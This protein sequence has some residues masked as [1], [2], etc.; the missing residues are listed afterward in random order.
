MGLGFAGGMALALGWVC[1]IFEPVPF[2]SCC[3]LEL[4]T[5]A[6]VDFSNIQSVRASSGRVCVAVSF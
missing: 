1:L 5:R 3:L 6:F 4:L 2:F